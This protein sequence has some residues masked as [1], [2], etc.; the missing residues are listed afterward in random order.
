M[1]E[2]QSG[3]RLAAL[4]S[5]VRLEPCPFC[6][7]TE[8]GYYEHVYAKHFSVMC[9]T[10]GAEGPRRPTCAEAARLWNRRPRG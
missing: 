4:M 6:T 7:S 9:D 1:P 2:Q 5:D 10:C 8:L 3:R